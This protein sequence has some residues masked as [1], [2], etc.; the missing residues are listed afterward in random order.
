MLSSGSSDSMPKI[1]WVRSDIPASYSDRKGIVTAALESGYVQIII[2]EEDEDLGR[3]GRYDVIFLKGKELY[4]DDEKIGELVEIESNE[5][6]K[7]AE[8]MRDKLEYLVISSHNWKVIP[9]ENL[10]S[11]FQGSRTKLL[12][13]AATPE[14]AKLFLETME[15]GADGIVIAPSS[16]GKLRD[17]I[18]SLE[19]EML[20]IE[21]TAVPVSRIAHL[22][23]G[24]R[25]CVDTCS[26]LKPGEGM[27]VG[28][29][30]AC[31][32]L[33]NSESLES[34]YVAAR[35]FRVNAG[36]VHA[37]ALTPS[38]KTRYL[39]EIKGGDEVL[40]V[41]SEGRSRRA[42]VGRA[43]VERRPL[44]LIEVEIEGRKFSTIVQNAETIRLC[45]PE[46]SVS[47][48]E[49]KEGQKVLVRLE[50]GGRHFG[51]SIDE[52]ITEV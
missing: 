29:Q 36:A 18:G 9:L 5:D 44:L 48:S 49:L 45:T 24:D 10:I 25:V 17:F 51:Q 28:S 16:G 27:L 35:P 41:D 21:L 11:W 8:G 34:E 26:L 43:K 4:L 19:N 23:I 1:V 13:S 42:V 2:R 12:A 15:H 52:T 38:G 50:Q 31:L 40:A 6:L 33:I 30:S 3:L 46:G 39:S 14:E 37:Y 47:V 22:T 32:F 7:E 20:R